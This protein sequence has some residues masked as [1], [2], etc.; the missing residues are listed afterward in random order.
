MNF[1]DTRKTLGCSEKNLM[2]DSGR[3]AEDHRACRNTTVK[4]RLSWFHAGTEAPF[5]VELET[6]FLAENCHILSHVLR[7]GRKLRLKTVN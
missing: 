2:G 1:R 7:F 6:N 3:R 5:T 4:A